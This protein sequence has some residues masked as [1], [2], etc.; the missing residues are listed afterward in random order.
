MEMNRHGFT[1]LEMVVALAIIALLSTV[2]SSVF[3][4]ILRTNT[5][6]E[7]LK[8]VKQNGEIALESMVRM[9]Q[10][11]RQVTTSCEST[12]TVVRSLSIVNSDGGTTTLECV[13]DGQSFRIASTSAQSTVY[14]TSGNVTLGGTSSC[15]QSTLAFTCF[16]ASGVPSSVMI[17]FS[18][19]QTGLPTGQAY[20]SSGETFQTTASLRNVIE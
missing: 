3:I 1:L 11:A 15:D 10:G 4:S 18:L 5:K 20:E 16:V 2:L 14:L 7:R 17:S 6:T 12:G 13:S 19:S 8:D 9:L